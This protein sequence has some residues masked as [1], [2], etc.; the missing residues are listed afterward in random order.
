MEDVSVGS[1]QQLLNTPRHL[2]LRQH[3][4]DGFI[5][6]RFRPR[7]ARGVLVAC[8]NVDED[9]NDVSGLIKRTSNAIV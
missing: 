2:P 8:P 3:P 4:P 1:A 6:I 5:H 9:L 7:F